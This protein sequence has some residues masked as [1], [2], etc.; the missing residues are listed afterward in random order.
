MLATVNNQVR[1]E[2]LAEHPC[3]NYNI[4]YF[5]ILFLTDISKADLL[6][7]NYNNAKYIN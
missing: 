5:A 4:E 1:A 2:F 7:T 6:S 3:Y